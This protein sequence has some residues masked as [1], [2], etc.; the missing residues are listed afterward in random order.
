MFIFPLKKPLALAETL[1]YLRGLCT[2]PLW[3]SGGFDVA[4]ADLLSPLPL[5]EAV[6]Q[7]PRAKKYNPV[8]DVSSLQMRS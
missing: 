5:G 7:L 1:A 2:R 3:V 8:K 4:G 6:C